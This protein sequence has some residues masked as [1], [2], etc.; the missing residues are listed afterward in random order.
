MC[1]CVCKEQSFTSSQCLRL[2]HT[3]FRG[4]K[5]TEFL[6]VC[7]FNLARKIEQTLEQIK[8]LLSGKKI[9]TLVIK[10]Q[11]GKGNHKSTNGGAYKV[12]LQHNLWTMCNKSGEHKVFS[13]LSSLFKI[14][15]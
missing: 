10:M 2:Q 5:N 7:L 1:V 11:R 12:R 6:F 4:K 15:S 9:K 14:G 13:K 8:L 3:A